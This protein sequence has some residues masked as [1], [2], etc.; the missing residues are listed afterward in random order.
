MKN[1]IIYLKVEDGSLK[2]KDFLPDVS[3]YLHI[4]YDENNNL[5]IQDS[6][7]SIFTLTDS[8]EMLFNQDSSKKNLFFNLSEK[9]VN[10][11]DLIRLSFNSTHALSIHRNRSKLLLFTRVQSK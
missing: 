9:P 7:G 5:F 6:Y 2:E 4:E 11:E 8:G 1:E 10:P 3:I